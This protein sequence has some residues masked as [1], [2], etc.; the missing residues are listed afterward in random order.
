[1]F[2]L[3][4]RFV[5]GRQINIPIELAGVRLCRLSALI[6]MPIALCLTVSG[7]GGLVVNQSA[8]SSLLSIPGTINFGT[9]TVGQS[10]TASI[11]ILNKSLTAVQI[12]KLEVD[13][14]TFSLNGSINLPVTIAP[15]STLQL[16]VQFNPST[17]GQ[18]TGQLVVATGTSQGGA[19]VVRLNGDG[20]NQAAPTLSGLSCAAASLTGPASDLCTVSLSA[21][22]QG[23]G[24]SIGLSSSNASL[25]VPATVSVPPGAVSATF[26]ATASAVTQ[27]QAVTLTVASASGSVSLAV[28]LNPVASVLSANAAAVNF[29][30]VAL[31]TTATQTVMLA[32]TGAAPVTISS[33]SVTGAGFTLEPTSLPATLAPG[34]SLT[35]DIDYAP[36]SAA[37]ATGQLVIGSNA[38]QGT[39]ILIPLSG[40]GTQ[41]GVQ[42]SWSAPIS[43]TDP[44][45]GYHVYRSPGTSAAY[46]LISSTGANSTTYED[47]TVESGTSYDYV[48]KAVDNSGVE[49]A[50]SN[51]TTA[52][53]P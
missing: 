5:S 48:V 19:A 16:Q 32:S 51:M 3:F 38:S 42:L 28:Q 33:V 29:G 26:T 11:P 18:A 23:T 1:M 46:Q 40:S 13:G 52:A 12:A 7:C 49:S 31:N 44:I 4:V 15:G 10:A 27:A 39:T 24:F 14:Q 41:F 21:P 22:A 34:Q 43:A 25:T 47:S 45:A 17:S 8:L 53:I 37:T 50:P 2:R 30:I 9:V 36:A 20:A 35:L 6:L